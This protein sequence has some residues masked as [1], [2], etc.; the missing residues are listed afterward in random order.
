M[1]GLDAL[2]KSL[3]EGSVSNAQKAATRRF[4]ERRTN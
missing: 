1:N 4:L 3:G 2:L